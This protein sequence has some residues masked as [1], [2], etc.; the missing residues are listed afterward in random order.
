[1]TEGK[2]TVQISKETVTYALDFQVTRSFE[3]VLQV[4]LFAC[5]LEYCYSN[6]SICIF[7]L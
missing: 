2:I 5:R 7:H 4:I 6:V 3:R 1:M